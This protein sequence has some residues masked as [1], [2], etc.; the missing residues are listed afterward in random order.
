MA[1]SDAVV[2]ICTRSDSARV[3]R[4]VFKRI[5]GVEAI[6]HIL[7]RIENVGYPIVLAV[8]KGEGVLYREYAEKLDNVT[9]HEGNDDSPLH[10]MAAV[11]EHREEP[12]VVRITHD[13]I[14]PDVLSIRDMV[15]L[16]IHEK[17][18]YVWNPGIFRGAD[19]EVISRQNLMRAAQTHDTPV[20]H[21][22]YVVNSH[23]P[24]KYN[25]RAA[26]ARD[27]R[28]S[29][30][31][32]EDAS[33]LEIILRKL[34]PW[35]SSE[36]IVGLIDLNPWL[37][38][39]NRLPIV[40]VYTC[41]KNGAKYI[42]EAM[43]SVL[44]QSINRGGQLEYIVIDDYSSDDTL[45][46]VSKWIGVGN[47]KLILNDK[48]MGLASS[49]NIALSKARGKYI[50]RVDADDKLYPDAITT[51]QKL[52]EETGKDVVYP[53]YN[54]GDGVA[55]DPTQ[56]THAAGALMRTALLNEIKFKDGIMHWDSLELY[57]RL[58]GRAG[59]AFYHR[60]LFYYRQHAES[61]SASGGEAR[62]QAR[63]EIVP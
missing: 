6:R 47:V 18:G 51:L 53:G 27:Y 41:V 31:Y 32:Q 59:V 46:E 55:K 19:A 26:I 17:A 30:D 42:G 56:Y 8:P 28:L 52:L 58:K 48:N 14:L 25:C 44:A 16:A 5:A 63:K 3:P 57:T 10:R 21:V 2:I 4:K 20:E 33:L 36:E 11:M 7:W 1:N 35:A 62:E 50:M 39:V 43:A 15:N 29:L 37:L 9:I 61:L 54:I 38:D 24:V 22:S 13:D 60:P 34:G 49:S 45:I 23:N 12:Y 40:T